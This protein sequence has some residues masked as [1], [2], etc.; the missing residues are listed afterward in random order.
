MSFCGGKLRL[1]HL[2]RFWPKNI[3]MNCR[4]S[5]EPHESKI[6]FV[7]VS[8]IKLKNRANKQFQLVDNDTRHIG[9]RFLNYNTVR[10]PDL[11]H[12][13]LSIFFRTCFGSACV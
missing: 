3:S 9:L 11:I 1:Y 2:E 5:A 13:R 4:Q 12:W 6:L 10:V 8:P 7:T